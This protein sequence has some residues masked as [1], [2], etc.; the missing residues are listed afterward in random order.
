[1]TTPDLRLPAEW[2]PQSGVMLTWP[3]ANSDWNES[4][5]AVESSFFRIAIEIARREMLLVNC[6]DAPMAN[7]IHTRLCEQGVPQQ[8]LV[9]AIAPSDD[10]WARDHGPLTRLHKGDPELM[11]FVFNGWG[12]KYPADQDNAITRRLARCGVFG[13]TPVRSVNLVLEGGSIDSDG[14][15][16]LLTTRRC[17]LDPQRNPGL[18][19]EAI[20][21]HLRD[22]LG[23][24]RVLWLENGELEGDDT[25]GHIDMLARFVSPEHIVYQ[26]CTEPDYPGYAALQAMEAELRAL[27]CASGKP[28]QLSALPWPSPK[29]KD[30]GERLPASY[31]NFL[32]INGALLQP[33]YE[34]SQDD[35]AA[36]QL[37]ACFPDRDI[38]QL[39][40][41]PL[42]QQFGS[43]HCVTLQFP[44]AVEFRHPNPG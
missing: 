29:Y 21:K 31:A 13:N 26:Q 37:Q 25:N 33:A 6:C 9:T 27:R 11:D 12:H 38:I 32:V 39:P 5:S 10:S 36:T 8:N 41:L 28:Y 4:L 24:E 15:G 44:S 23:I 30:N 20:E 16:S 34:D 42:I 2:E 22:L 14:T 18:D 40:C 19:S 7:R 35:V 3:H 43:L 17:L 1:M